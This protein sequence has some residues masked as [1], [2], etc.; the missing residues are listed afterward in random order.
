[1]P[2]SPAFA[3]IGVRRRGRPERR[4]VRR[5]QVQGMLADDEDFAV[6]QR[7]GRTHAATSI[8]SGNWTAR[9]LRANG[10]TR[11]AN[12]T[13]GGTAFAAW[14]V[15]STTFTELARSGVIPQARAVELIDNALFALE[16]GW[17]RARAAGRDL[18]A[19]FGAAQAQLE[20]LHKQL[21]T[22]PPVDGS[23]PG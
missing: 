22:M 12:D 11:M 23:A 7:E 13:E 15:A 17:G 18:D 4:Y 9:V 5:G 6:G 19:L 14:M 1:M 10:E 16:Q 2:A 8:A 21:R 3:T 20:G